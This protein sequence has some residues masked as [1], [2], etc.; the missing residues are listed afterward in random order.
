MTPGDPLDGV[1]RGR[2]RPYSGVTVTDDG[3]PQVTFR[4][5]MEWEGSRVG[6]LVVTYRAPELL[7]LT[8]NHRGLGET[9]ETLVLSA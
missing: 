1:E 7:E 6:T 5:P 2:R 4:A 8:D 9:G 3:P